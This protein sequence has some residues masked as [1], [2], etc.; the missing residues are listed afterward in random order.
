MLSGQEERRKDKEIQVMAAI[1]HMSFRVKDPQRSAEL[2]AELLGGKLINPGPQLSTIDVKSIAFG[3]D[4]G[5][6]ADMMEFW[7]Q[8]KHWH[9]GDFTSSDPGHH[10]P[11]GH[12]AFE[13]DK[14]YEEL[15]A[16][17]E[18]HG[19]LICQEER[20]LASLVPVVYDY[21]GN[22]LE[23]FPATTVA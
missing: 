23:F 9:A 13:T 1:L 20:G 18:K 6:L 19:V 12:V 8:D 22:F 3:K 16:I 2:Y 10:Q 21:E 14:S 4:R 5:A 11:F 15:A 7:P 17:A